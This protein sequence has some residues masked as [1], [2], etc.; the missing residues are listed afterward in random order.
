MKPHRKLLDLKCGNE[1]I[2]V[3]DHT[4]KSVI[5]SSVKEDVLNYDSSVQIEKTVSTSGEEGFKQIFFQK[6]QSTDPST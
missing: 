5:V 1:F 4:N 3:A 2:F 6:S